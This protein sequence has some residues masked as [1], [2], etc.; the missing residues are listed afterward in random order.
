MTEFK[1]KAKRRNSRI[2]VRVRQLEAQVAEIL[3][4]ANAT[5]H[6]P[7]P[8]DRDQLVRLVSSFELAADGYRAHVQAAKAIAAASFSVEASPPRETPRSSRAGW[9]ARQ[10]AALRFFWNRFGL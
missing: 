7:P 4:A 9:L 8:L 5:A 2:E 3:R 6:G 10:Q 1:P